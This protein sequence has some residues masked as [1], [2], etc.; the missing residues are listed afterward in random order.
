MRG[1]GTGGGVEDTR[2]ERKRDTDRR[3]QEEE[4]TGER[5]RRESKMRDRERVWGE[6]LPV[7]V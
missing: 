5:R 1:A 4:R 2:E 3:L 6:I 7:T